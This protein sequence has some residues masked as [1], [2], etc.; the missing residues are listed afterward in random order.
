MDDYDLHIQKESHK[1]EER[2]LKDQ[3]ATGDETVRESSCES[4]SSSSCRVNDNQIMK[5]EPSSSVCSMSD[6]GNTAPAPETNSTETAKN[7]LVSEIIDFVSRTE[8][9]IGNEMLILKSLADYLKTLETNIDLTPCGSTTYGFGGSTTN[10]N[11][12]VN[13]SEKSPLTLMAKFEKSF[14]TSSVRCDFEMLEYLSSNRVQ[15]RRYQLMHKPSKILCWLQFDRDTNTIESS[16]I[17]RN[18]IKQSPICKLFGFPLHLSILFKL[19]FDF[20]TGFH[21]IAVVRSLQN[22]M[23]K[24]LAQDGFNTYII[25]VLVIFFLQVNYKFPKIKD[26]PLSECKSIDIIPII[27]E[28]QLK[29]SVAEFFNFYGK[30]LEVGK[31]LI[32]TNIGRWQERHLQAKQSV[33][34]PEQERF[35]F[36][37]IFSKLFQVFIRMINFSLRENIDLNPENWKNCTL[38]VQDIKVPGMNIAA[39]ISEEET[40]TFKT[41]CQV[42]SSENLYNKTIDDYILQL[43][44]V[45]PVNPLVISKKLSD[46][47]PKSSSS[48]SLSLGNTTPTTS[49]TSTSTFSMQSL[50]TAINNVEN[51]TGSKTSKS[52]RN[53]IKI[54]DVSNAAVAEMK[55]LLKRSQDRIQNEAK[56]M[57]ILSNFFTKIDSTSKLVPFGS[58]TY[59]FGGSRINFNILLKID[60]SKSSFE[61]FAYILN[62]FKY[63][64]FHSK[65]LR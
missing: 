51:S 48:S 41:V 49:K 53:I 55:E 7:P 40:I 45:Q 26:V 63:D 5:L 21:L 54:V 8:A 46:A 25:A 12:L 30:K 29:K 15:K 60:T 18:C 13:I 4:K 43:S 19:T 59:G 9:R 2:K 39:E 32:S 16:Q 56:I 62:S 58:S 44:K 47:T 52:L 1:Q 23:N 37:F 24:T 17:I 6:N 36:F 50:K 3:N 20:S 11:I 14:Q 38:Y 57:E 65:N 22:V 34:T 28:K 61:C 31:H 27:D 33:F 64:I 42:I 35:D 10:F